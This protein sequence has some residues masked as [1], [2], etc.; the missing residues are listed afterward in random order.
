MRDYIFETYLKRL[1]TRVKDLKE[2]YSKLDKADSS[3]DI[4]RAFSEANIELSNSLTC[5]LQSFD[6]VQDAFSGDKKHFKLKNSKRLIDSLFAIS[7]RSVRLGNLVIDFK[8]RLEKGL[9]ITEEQFLSIE[10]LKADYEKI[11]KKI[12]GDLKIMEDIIN[13]EV[14][15]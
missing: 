1:E 7:D 2:Y 3:D 15:N 13:K 11:F 6:I 4:K 14:L 8:N 9:K 10:K 5:V 12:D